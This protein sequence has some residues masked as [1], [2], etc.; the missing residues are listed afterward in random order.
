MAHVLLIEPDYILAGTYADALGHAGY[1]VQVAANAQTA[2]DAADK[3]IP[4]VVVL[5]LQLAEHNGI[6]F[7]YEFRSYN[8][9]RS[10]PVIIHSNLSSADME[11]AG[12]LWSQLGI[13]DYHYKPT[14]SL[15]ALLS[16]VQ[17]AAASIA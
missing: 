16:S 5:E 13:V 12:E 14:S 10:V 8:E 9:W 6:E 2:I 7:L 17:K 11:P 4:D 3:T 1:S 15:K